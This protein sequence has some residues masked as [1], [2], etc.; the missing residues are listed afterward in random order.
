L[1]LAQAS[2]WVQGDDDR[3]RGEFALVIE[4][5]EVESRQGPDPAVLE[6]LLAE[7]PLK[8]AVSLAA[9]LTG[10]KRNALYAMALALKN[11]Q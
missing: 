11:R 2:A 4:G 9:K 10:A 7:L 5:R 6:T 8:Q 3:R 1:P